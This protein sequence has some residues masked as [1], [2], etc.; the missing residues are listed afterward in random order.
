MGNMV[1]VL[2]LL[3]FGFIFVIGVVLAFMV[4]LFFI[5]RFQTKD[6][7][8]RNYPVIGHLRGFFETLGS[9]SDSIFSP[10]T[11]KKCRLTGR[12]VTG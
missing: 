7:V 1:W 4:V 10:W 12:S 11:E 9:S 6:A 3:A 2:E 8:R 5:D